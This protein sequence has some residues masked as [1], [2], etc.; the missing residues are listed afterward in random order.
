MI[1]KQLLHEMFLLGKL[2]FAMIVEAKINVE[3][4]NN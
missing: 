1:I 3:M 2:E 4:N